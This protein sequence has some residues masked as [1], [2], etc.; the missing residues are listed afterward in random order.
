MTDL[1]ILQEHPELRQ[2][3][4]ANP[5]QVST[6]FALKRAAYWQ[7]DLGE[8]K[9]DFEERFR[10]HIHEQHQEDLHAIYYLRNAI[11]HSHVSL[12]RDY[13][14]YRPGRGE[15]HEAAMRR[16]LTLQPVENQAHPTMMTLR[17]YD[18]QRYLADFNRIKRLDEE[19]FSAIAAHLSIPHGRIR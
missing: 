15:K 7:K 18:D 9:R 11:A 14:L 17:L 5:A 1:L 10:D 8:V 13:L 4:V 12:A 2:P 3:F 19:C 6:D 16:V